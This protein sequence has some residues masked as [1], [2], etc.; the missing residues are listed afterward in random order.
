MASFALFAHPAVSR[1]RGAL[2]SRLV[3]G[4]M[5]AR[6][7]AAARVEHQRRADAAHQ[8]EHGHRCLEVELLLRRAGDVFPVGLD[9]KRAEQEG[10]ADETVGGIGGAGE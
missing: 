4:E 3:L 6:D 5:A 10:G 7:E 8:R 2:R 9:G 1:V